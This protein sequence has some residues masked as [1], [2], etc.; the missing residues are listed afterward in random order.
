ML[1]STVLLGLMVIWCGTAFAKG[2]SGITLTTNG[3]N[4]TVY[5]GIAANGTFNILCNENDTAQ[6][7]THN[8][9]KIETHVY[10]CKFSDDKAHTITI[11]GN[12]TEYSDDEEMSTFCLG[13]DCGLEKNENTI[14][15]SISGS[16]GDVFGTIVD[17]DGKI[18]QQPSFINSFY[19]LACLNKWSIPSD[20]FGSKIYGDLQR[21]MFE[22]TF[23]NTNIEGIDGNLFKNLSG[24]L[25][26]YV[27]AGTFSSNKSLTAIPD[28]LF[29]SFTGVPDEYSLSDTF[30]N[31]SIS[32]FISPNLFAT[33][34]SKNMSATAMQGIFKDNGFDKDCPDGY[35]QYTTGFEDYFDG[36]VSCIEKVEDETNFEEKIKINTTYLPKN[37]EFKFFIS[38]TGTFFVDW[39]DKTK[40]EKIVRDDTTESVYTHVYNDE[41][42]YTIRIGGLATAYNSGTVAAIRFGGSGATSTL[43]DEFEGM[44]SDLF[45][46]LKDANQAPK[47]IDTFNGCSNIQYISDMFAGYTIPQ[48]SMF[49]RTFKDCLSLDKVSGSI[50]KTFTTSEP[51]MFKQTFENCTSLTSLPS[52]LFAEITNA[53]TYLFDS[54]FKGCS[55]LSGYIPSTF[56]AGLIKN[57]SPY[58]AGMWKDTFYGTNL[59]TSCGTANLVTTGYEDYWDDL[60]AC[61]QE[62]ENNFT[63]QFTITTI[64]GTI[65]LPFQISAMGEFF[66][67]CGY[68]EDGKPQRFKI[69][70]TDTKEEKYSCSWKD[71][72]VHVVEF[73]G[74]ATGYSDNEKTSAIWFYDPYPIYMV[75]GSIGHVF[76][77]IV[78]DKGDIQQPSFAGLFNGAKNLTSIS[79]NLFDG[80][81]GGAPYMFDGA[82]AGCS[83]LTSV[84]VNLFK[85]ITDPADYEFDNTFAG[86]TSLTNMPSF[87]NV[88]GLASRSMFEYTF[89]ECSSLTGFVP[90]GMFAG[91]SNDAASLSEMKAN[92]AM[93][94][95]FKGTELDTSCNPPFMQDETGF[96]QFWETG[97]GSA[98]SCYTED[99]SNFE[100]KFEI[101]TTPNTNQ[102]SVTLSAAGT[103][104]VDAGGAG[105]YLD[106]KGNPVASDGILTIERKDTKPTT[107][108]Y[109]YNAPKNYTIGFGGHVDD[110]DDKNYA[111]AISFDGDTAQNIAGVSGRIANLFKPIVMADGIKKLPSFKRLFHGASNLTT[112][113]Y[114]EMFA[115]LKNSGTV[116][117]MFQETFSGCSGITGEIPANLFP[118]RGS[119]ERLFE[120]TFENCSGLS[121]SIPGTLFIGVDAK[122]SAY[123]FNST[124]SGCSGL[125]GF[126]SSLLFKNVSEPEAY[127]TDMMTN[128]FNG[129]TS[130][131]TTC[132]DG[133]DDYVYP[134]GFNN[135]FGGVAV[136]KPQGLS[137]TPGFTIKVEKG[138]K[139][140]AWSTTATGVYYVDCGNGDDVYT[141]IKTN[142]KSETWSCDYTDDPDVQHEITFGRDEIAEQTY[143]KDEP[144]IC[145]SNKC[146]DGKSDPSA[147]VGL[148]G[149]ISAVYPTLLDGTNPRFDH[150]FE[151]ATNLNVEISPN[152]F[153]GLTG[154]FTDYMFQNSFFDTKIYGEFPANFFGNLGNDKQVPGNST[155]QQTFLGTGL[156]GNI[157]V[158]FLTKFPTDDDNIQKMIDNK[159]FVGMFGKTQMETTS[160]PNRYNVIPLTEKLDFHA[161]ACEPKTKIDF[162]PKFTF[163]TSET[164]SVSFA[165]NISTKNGLYVDCDDGYTDVYYP[166]AG[167]EFWVACNYDE[168]KSHTV[169]LGGDVTAYYVG[170]IHRPNPIFQFKDPAFI[171]GASD[172]SKMFPTLTDKE[173]QDVQPNFSRMFEGTNITEI[174]VMKYLRGK[175]ESNMFYRM[176]ANTG[177]QGD[178]PDNIVPYM[179]GIPGTCAFCEMF[180]GTSGLTGYIPWQFIAPFS[181]KSGAKSGTKGPSGDGPFAGAFEGTGMITVENGGCPENY[182][183]FPNDFTEGLDGYV[184]C[185][186]DENV[187]NFERKFTITTTPDTTSFSIPICDASGTFFIDCG[188][189]KT[190]IRYDLTD[191]TLNTCGAWHICEYDAPGVYQISL[192]GLATKYYYDYDND[193][194]DWGQPTV[195]FSWTGSEKN[196]IASI[197]GSLGAIFPTISQ[198]QQPGFNGIFS[199]A[200][201]LSGEIPADLFKGI[202]G[203][204]RNGM[205]GQTFNNTN[206]SGFI[207]PELFANISNDAASIQTIRNNNAM[208]DIFGNDWNLAY[209]CPAGYM[210]YPTGFEEF[211]DSHVSCTEIGEWEPK[212]TITT[213]SNTKY[214]G[215]DIRA[216]GTFY[217]DWGDGTIEARRKNVYTD[218]RFEH[219]YNDMDTYEI[220]IGGLATDYPEPYT[221]DDMDKSRDFSA[222]SFA[223][224]CY[225]DYI[226]QISG[227]LG[228]I[229]P[230][231]DISGELKQPSFSGTFYGCG[232]MGIENPIPNKLFVGVYGQPIPYMFANTF[233]GANFNAIPGD[234][235]GRIDDN[236][237]YDGING[238]PA[239]SMFAGTF[240]SCDLITSLPATLFGRMVDDEYY[241]VQGS[242]AEKM[243]YNTFSGASS[244]SGF[245]PPELFAGISNKPEDIQEMYNNEAMQGVFENDSYL[246]SQCPSG[247]IQYITGFE[248][249]FGEHVSCYEGTTEN[250]NRVFWVG[251]TDNTSE[252]SFDL[253]AAGTFFIDWGDDVKEKIVHD[254]T[255]TIT[256]SHTYET[257][258]SY[259]IGFGGVA[260]SYNSR[261]IPAISFKNNQN[262]RTIDG[263]LVDMFGSFD[264]DGPADIY[265]HTPSFESTFENCQNLTKGIPETLFKLSINNPTHDCNGDG[266]IDDKDRGKC[267][268]YGFRATD[269]TFYNM[270]KND[271]KLVGDIPSDLFVDVNFYDVPMLVTDVFAGM[272]DGCENLGRDEIGGNSTY[273]ISPELFWWK[274]EMGEEFNDIDVGDITMPNVFRGT[275]LLTECPSGYK[276]YDSILESAWSGKVACIVD[277][278][279]EP[280]NP[281]EPIEFEPKFTINTESLS[282]FEFKIR[283]AGTFYVDWGDGTVEEITKGVF[284]N[285]D[286]YHRYSRYGD[287]TIKLG[288]LATD[289]PETY[290][291]DDSSQSYKYAA[292]S[293][294]MY[295]NGNKCQNIVSISGSLG[296]I[297]PTLDINGELKQPSF[298][299]TFDWCNNLGRNA[300]IPDT[301]FIGIYGQ[302]IP[303][304][305]AR[306]FDSNRWNAIPADL[307]GRIDDNGNY[308]GI[309]GN[310]TQD[311]FYST[312]GSC[313]EI[314]GKIPGTLFGR[315]IDNEYYGLQG[316]AVQE[317]FL[318]TFYGNRFTG[319]IPPE[320]FAGISN[321]T[322]DIEIMYSNNAM[323]DVFADNES[324]A[325]SCPSGYTQY[326]TKF[327]D[328]WENKVSCW[329]RS[330]NLTGDDRYFYIDVDT[331][332]NGNQP[333]DVHFDVAAGRFRIWW[334]YDVVGELT[335]DDNDNIIENPEYY[336]TFEVNGG[337]HLSHPYNTSGVHHIR[338]ERLSDTVAYLPGLQPINIEPHVRPTIIGI[339]GSLGAVFPTNDTLETEDREKKQPRF[340]YLFV[341]AYNMRGEIPENLFVGVHGPVIKGM[342]DSMFANCK[343]LSGKI[344]ENLFGRFVDDGQ[345]NRQY[346]GITGVADGAYNKMF[347]GTK[348]TGVVPLG[349]FAGITDTNGMQPDEF[350]GEIFSGS[351]MLPYCPAGD[352]Q[353]ITGLESAW[354]V[355]DYYTLAC[356]PGEYPF[357]VTVYPGNYDKESGEQ[358]DGQ[359]CF[360]MSA[361]G[362]FSVNWGDG[363]VET[364]VREDTENKTYCHKYVDFE[365][366]QSYTIGFNGDTVSNDVGPATG[367]STTDSPISFGLSPYSY[368]V[369]EIHGKLGALFPTIR[370]ENTNEILAQPRFINTFSRCG[371][372]T[373]EIPADLFDG[374][375]GQPVDNMFN[376]T[377]ENCSGLTG[378]IPGGLFGGIAGAPAENMFANTFANDSGLT[379]IGN[380]LF[381][382]I[383]G[384]AAAG[385]YDSTF[386][387][388]YSIS[389]VLQPNMFGNITGAPQPSMYAHTFY[390]CYNITG[391]IPSKFFGTFNGAPA[392]RMFRNTFNACSNITGEI[393]DDLFNGINGK[394]AE[395]MFA[396]TFSSC[397]GL[398]GEIPATLFAGISGEPARGMFAGTFAECPGLTGIGGPLFSGIS[399]QPA[400]SM[401]DTTFLYDTGLR[402]SIPPN[403][404]GNVYGAPA[405]AMY[406]GTF[407]FCYGL[408]GTIPDNL[409]G[410]IHGAPAKG[411]YYGT[412]MDT[413]GLTGNIPSR[414]FGRFDVDGNPSEP[415]GYMFAMTFAGDA[416]LTG[417]VP[418]ELFENISPT[419]E[420][421]DMM[422]MVFAGT[423]LD[424]ECEFPYSQINTGFEDYWNGKVSCKACQQITDV[425]GI[426]DG[427]YDYCEN[428]TA[429]NVT[430]PN[431][432]TYQYPL[433]KDRIGAHRIAVKNKNDNTICYAPLKSD[434]NIAP[435]EAVRGLKIKYNNHKYTPIGSPVKNTFGNLNL[436]NMGDDK[437]G[438][439]LID[440]PKNTLGR[441]ASSRKMGG[442]SLSNIIVSAV[443]DVP[444][445]Q[446]VDT[447]PEFTPMTLEEFKVAMD[448]VKQKIRAKNAAQK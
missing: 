354:K 257:P 59:A 396:E 262:V 200:T 398:T 412:F 274:E 395:L 250:F 56:I 179:Y 313:Y 131:D 69:T 421:E 399:G 12:A 141:Y 287:Y 231:L 223:N 182:T 275:G 180:N 99:A 64:N 44:F 446:N 241:G 311:L 259:T 317:T 315:T 26:E 142:N 377:F 389:S 333:I 240:Q 227:S 209:Q 183:E 344:P 33:L 192:G 174:P 305:F 242:A 145:F 43:I 103:F 299:S 3:K 114:G 96:E 339:D 201:N 295:E 407:A 129:A 51:K 66:V 172:P 345:G 416:G 156:I 38:A 321:T 58:A 159:T 336:E 120:K 381:A 283:A 6:T 290:T 307:F 426:A 207:P 303:Y 214:F 125:T 297:F 148:T 189:G 82:F 436:G 341:D 247:Y 72:G 48:T 417:F 202:Y 212:F 384:D 243:F 195:P 14:I 107:Y 197:S 137:F 296:A 19:N 378:E 94:G 310:P 357:A 403:L 431:G 185:Y 188:D 363:T 160:C 47:F 330:N 324:L 143:S 205:F 87:E 280:N 422:T 401:F 248:T 150:L 351:N 101:T 424:T 294:G 442:G 95:I 254:D 89:G 191:T 374:V 102:I 86:C 237:N 362:K 121:G 236:G 77:T 1:Y 272:F 430:G 105:S 273:F 151:N 343:E 29:S 215:F 163:T 298:S 331:T 286:F 251:T 328:F 264:S 67:N 15:A 111:A 358:D 316:K 292:I 50:F 293:F 329:V 104:F 400:E 347:A 54:T 350:M 194:G 175:P 178:L 176:F 16:M 8:D 271:K 359:F 134:Q 144:A 414:L 419:P 444:E 216:A 108:T 402:G 31:C 221:D 186:P 18:I 199:G 70:R 4:G 110:Y 25:P 278:S 49:E 204:P 139:N 312:F 22:R 413:L 198:A 20:F 258:N 123:M 41:G 17:K 21:C 429:I 219:Y 80:V 360:N 432:A 158:E 427:C 285:D 368:D 37:T 98:V 428:N 364:I 291:G 376:G 170:A 187:N 306:T 232:G 218:D 228:A 435:E 261:H 78:G 88:I 288:G 133:Y 353:V 263:S 323:R 220:K 60:V 233:T 106:D 164:D 225:E 411:M 342:F 230:T 239:K 423:R 256:V 269:R 203:I 326:I 83:S 168:K 327:E 349:L 97:K 127:S 171:V 441:G 392:E 36:A 35:E 124:F 355:G 356:A 448:K 265:T 213:T 23:S 387:S 346:V 361:R 46:E 93:S 9:D 42:W 433:F 437:T 443:T 300:V 153:Q 379:S 375:S 68:Y 445:T 334:D 140:F 365:G 28:T 325:R 116:P 408:S 434:E 132:P 113:L 155:F 92:D 391:N 73:G 332:L 128:I 373:G 380:G 386:A 252:F 385:M 52:H 85:D 152:W 162:E 244:L 388:C 314:T 135:Y 439:N 130:M 238:Q 279:N 393:P 165:V 301:L 338:I 65:A 404:F 166:Q 217:V 229:F 118:I 193:N 440:I 40:P 415:A 76:P 63:P 161:V 206:L 369:T 177:Y 196:N 418:P 147:I 320:L 126:I 75:N 138:T 27:F 157:P 268:K 10:N 11:T 210:Q 117:S 79:D 420:A 319:F 260:T 119:S 222:I 45:P 281:E 91:L 181:T 276:K 74:K 71:A 100:H 266:V 136:C 390:G 154:N 7:Y 372:L 62:D 304:M 57:K 169:K 253:S 24:T 224:F 13:Q 61:Q 348:I 270:F 370:D 122:P 410:N 211:F 55:D 146:G 245:V 308:D 115:D 397:S 335:L 2:E 235:F 337:I 234:L 167:K 81:F 282:R 5:I 425:A 322:Q 208:D 302:P 371:N 409:F 34:S 173:G 447:E 367:Y 149:D 255:N 53:S 39:G 190:P 90:R 405:D 383:S 32:G 277:N 289:Y 184:V 84:P 249:F 318:N 394:P 366:W 340:D 284:D 112:P 109:F 309:Y 352:I 246:A 406:M 438:S 382:G 267:Y 226:D 30:N